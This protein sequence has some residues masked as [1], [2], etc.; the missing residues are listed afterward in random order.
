MISTK[1]QI[2]FCGHIHLPTLYSMSVTAKMTSFVPTSGMP[3]QLLKGRQWLAVA[4]SVG[5]PR[6][7]NPAACFLTFDTQSRELT[8]CRGG[9][10]IEAAAQRI[11]DN[12]LPPRLADRL[13]EGR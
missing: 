12:G 4:G 7:H 5:Q 3:V 1:A 8:Y 2:S 13:F 10:D 11:R 6:D 9:Y